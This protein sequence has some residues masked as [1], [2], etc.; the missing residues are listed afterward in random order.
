MNVRYQSGQIFDF[1]SI[2][3]ENALVETED[4]T[5]CIFDYSNYISNLSLW[6]QVMV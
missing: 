1:D 2:S 6:L 4:A 5:T 3:S